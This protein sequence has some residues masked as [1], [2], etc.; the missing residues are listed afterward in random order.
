MAESKNWGVGVVVLAIKVLVRGT[1]HVS[2]SESATAP[3]RKSLSQA[4]LNCAEVIS[5]SGEYSVPEVF[6]WAEE[7]GQGFL[8]MELVDAPTLTRCWGQLGEEGRVELCR[9]LGGMV[10]AWRGLVQQQGG[11][12]GYIGSVTK[13]PSNDIRLGCRP[14]LHSPWLGPRAVENLHDICYIELKPDTPET[15]T[16]LT[17]ITFTHND[18]AP[19]NVLVRPSPGIPGTPPRVAAV[20]DWAQAGW[21]PACW[22]W[23]KAELTDMPLGE[24][25]SREE[26]AEWKEK[27]LPLAVEALPDEGVFWPWKRFAV[28]YS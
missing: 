4:F 5:Y 22:E 12:G 7:D 24:G 3:E 8:Y 27:Y 17:A 11:R 25:M 16:A 28:T 6:G 2:L 13:L 9:E 19:C 15:L 14:H 23:C 21:Y 26:Q 1:W 10:R 18:L 20:I